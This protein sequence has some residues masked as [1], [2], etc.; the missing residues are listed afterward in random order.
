MWVPPITMVCGWD[1]S[2]DFAA[3]FLFSSKLAKNE[4]FWDP[5]SS[6]RRWVERKHPVRQWLPSTLNTNILVASAL[7]QQERHDTVGF[8]STAFIAGTPRCFYVYPGRPGSPAYM[9]PST[10]EGSVAPWDWSICWH[11][12]C[13]HL[14]EGLAPNSNWRLRSGVVYDN[15]NRKPV[16][17]WSWLPTHTN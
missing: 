3:A 15:G 13:M 14:R 6:L 8:F 1:I 17:S 2:F 16:P 5:V 12:I 9:H 11:P 10:G 7:N 4:G